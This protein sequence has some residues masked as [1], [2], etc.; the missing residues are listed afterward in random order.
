VHA[1]KS[2]SSTVDACQVYSIT[3]QIEEDIKANKTE[4]L[5][6]LCKNLET[7]CHNF[8]EVYRQTLQTDTGEK[9]ANK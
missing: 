6:A 8:E 5:N 1:L 2:S 4:T 3:K 9:N 7:A